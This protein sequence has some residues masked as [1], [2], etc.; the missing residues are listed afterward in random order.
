MANKNQ[1]RYP[2]E[3]IQTTI[4]KLEE[5]ASMTALA[6]ELGIAK[7]TISYWWVNA[8]KFMGNG[9]TEGLNPK[10][11]R[12]Q[13]LIIEYGWKSCLRAIRRLNATMDE[14]SF[15]DLVTG[16]TEL[17]QK[18]T[19]LRPLN[20]NPRVPAQEIQVSEERK[21]TVKNFLQ[22]QKERFEGTKTNLGD[23][24][25]DDPSNLEKESKPGEAR[26]TKEEANGA[27]G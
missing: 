21:V 7:S 8:D 20:A 16:V 13:N 4:T 24:S 9:F 2:L 12:I 25:S 17:M 26:A 19:Q 27:N 5:G 22:K 6:A 10:V 15:R 14:A 18:L 1:Q 3:T 11:I 23:A